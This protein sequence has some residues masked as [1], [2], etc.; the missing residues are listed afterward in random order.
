MEILIGLLV[1]GAVLVLS[2]I[3]TVQQQTVVLIERFGR[4]FRIAG[5]GLQY[6]IPFIDRVAGKVTLRLTQ[7]NVN[8]ET[9]TQD[10]VFVHLTV[11]VQYKILPEKV[12]EAF[13]TLDD[14]N[15]QIRAYVFD[16]VRAEIPNIKLDDVFSR[17]DSIADAVQSELK[18]VMG[19]FGYDILKALITDI[20]PDAK[21][22][23]AMNEINE[24]Q[25]LRYAAMERGEAEK[26]L[27]IKHAEAE[28]ESKILQGQ[29]LAGQRKAI[30]EGMQE[31]LNRFQTEIPNASMQDVM[32]LIVL[33]QYFDTLKEL[34]AHGKSNTVFL[35]HAPSHSFFEEL[36]TTLLSTQKD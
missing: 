4:F 31:S 13:Y 28:A 35:P 18:D 7:L 16:V 27:K 26:I 25:R 29:G 34:G 12:Y 10:N 22:K 6:K 32:H 33:S 17:K 1:V 23:A 3:F 21:V 5:S 30:L 24:A 19:A 15:E 36:R 11:S 8:I 14:A 20:N 9:K 2:S